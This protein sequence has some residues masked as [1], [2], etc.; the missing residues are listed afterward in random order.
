MIRWK[1]MSIRSWTC[2]GSGADAEDGA[3]DRVEIAIGAVGCRLELLHVGSHVAAQ[4]DRQPTVAVVDDA[5]EGPLGL[6]AEQDV[7]AVLLDRLGVAPDRVEVDELAVE[8]GLV[9]RPEFSPGEH[10]LAGHLPAVLEVPAV[11]LELFRVPTRADAENQ[12]AAGDHV[13]G[14][15]RF[16]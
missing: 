7:G 16:G 13:E 14:C 6:R 9:L 3:V 12:A 11:I 1:P 15:S 2:F 5:V 4:G 8:L 10:D